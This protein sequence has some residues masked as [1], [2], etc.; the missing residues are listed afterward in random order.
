MVGGY[1]LRIFTR[2]HE[3]PNGDSNIR[4][5][6]SQFVIRNKIMQ[7]FKDLIPDALRR[8][9]ISHEIAT[10]NVVEAFNELM[11]ERLP[12]ARKQD[13]QANGYKDKTV[14]VVCRNAMAAH[15]VTSHELE[16]IAALS[17][18]VPEAP[19]IKIK[20]KNRVVSYDV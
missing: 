3:C 9:R 14:F 5:F 15:W 2:I 16:L 1:E 17:R 11:A 10:V 12:L 13:V 19:V 20:P 7:S 8:G 4:E 6:V 18:K